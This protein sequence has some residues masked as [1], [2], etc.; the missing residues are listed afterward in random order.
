MTEEYEEHQELREVKKES[1]FGNMSNFSLTILGIIIFVVYYVLRSGN[2]ELRDYIIG[3][4]IFA[5]II[6]AISKKTNEKKIDYIKA[7]TA[8]EILLNWL[9]DYNKLKRE[10]LVKITL[11]QGRVKVSPPALEKSPFDLKTPISWQIGF[12]IYDEDDN[13]NPNPFLSKI[14]PVMGGVGLEEIQKLKTE[15][16]GIPKPIAIKEVP[17]PIDKYYADM[18]DRDFTR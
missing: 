13:G 3:I 4:G 17:I 14:N 11:P 6:Y 9:R 1:P 10:G 16:N 12:T 18:R 8:R 15:F 2:A 7:D 5:A